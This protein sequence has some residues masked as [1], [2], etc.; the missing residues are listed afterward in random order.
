MKEWRTKWPD[1]FSNEKF[2]LEYA[3][4][5]LKYQVNIKQQKNYKK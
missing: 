5:R 1:R 2:P 3:L 4:F